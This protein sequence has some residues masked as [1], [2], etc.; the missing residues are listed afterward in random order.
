[1]IDDSQFYFTLHVIKRFVMSGSS[2]Q[3]NISSL[4][5]LNVIRRKL[6]Y[7]HFLIRRISRNKF[8]SMLGQAI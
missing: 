3:F 6:C 1:M 7:V 2:W 4:D 8:L 5:I